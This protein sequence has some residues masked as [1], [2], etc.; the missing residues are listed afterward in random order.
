M[1]VKFELSP[2]IR[3]M[4]MRGEMAGVIPVVPVEHD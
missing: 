1:S 2:M 4:E 3:G